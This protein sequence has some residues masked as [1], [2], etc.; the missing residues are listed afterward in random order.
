MKKSKRFFFFFFTISS[1]STW[2]MKNDLKIQGPETTIPRMNRQLE[3]F[4]AP[5]NTTADISDSLYQRDDET[6]YLASDQRTI[7][8]ITV[9]NTLYNIFETSDDTLNEQLKKILIRNIHDNP[10]V[11]GSP[12]DPYRMNILNSSESEQTAG[13]NPGD[14]DASTCVDF[15]K[16][17]HDS[18]DNITGDFQCFLP[19]HMQVQHHQVSTA[20][21]AGLMQKTCA[22]IIFPEL[23]SDSIDFK[24]VTLLDNEYVNSLKSKSCSL[25]ICKSL[26]TDIAERMMLQF[27]PF[28]ANR[29]GNNPF[30]RNNAS[31][32]PEELIDDIVGDVEKMMTTLERSESSLKFSLLAYILCIEPSWH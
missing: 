30:K 10:F 24:E 26:S 23:D 22:E 7:D 6:T 29:V 4:R 17:C 25:E 5:S 27:Y 19:S 18:G 21:R 28:L 12:C 11:F 32:I 1:L 16:G 14:T 20:L 3:T 15:E 8:K 2:A 13:S 9:F 31:K